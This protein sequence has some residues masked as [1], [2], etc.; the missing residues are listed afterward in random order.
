MGKILGGR[1]G[2]RRQ[3]RVVRALGV[4]VGLVVLMGGISGA[5]FPRVNPKG[6]GVAVSSPSAI[7]DLAVVSSEPSQ[8]ISGFGASGA[9]W[10]RDAKFFPAATR[11][12]IGRLLFSPQGIDL[13]TYRFYIGGGGV[14]VDQ[15]TPGESETGSYDRAQDGF[16]LGPDLYDWANEQGEQEFL[17]M[18]SA[19]HVPNLV[20]MSYSAPPQWTTDG[21]NCG[22]SIVTAD[23]G[24]YAAYLTTIVDHFHQEGINF[25]YV[26]AMNEPA[27]AFGSTSGCAQEGMVVPV[28]ERGDLVQA[29]GEDLAS[30]APYARVIAPDDVSTTRFVQ[31][32]PEWMS[33][34][35]VAKYVAA[36]TYHGYNFP[37][38]V[39][40]RAVAAVGKEF[41]KPT[42]MT[43]ICCE[44]TTTG[45]YG[46]QYNPTMSSGMWLATF[47]YQALRYSHDSSFQWWTALSAAMGCDPATD[48]G[49][50]T[51]VRTNAD[52]YNDGLIYYDPN[53][54]KDKD[55][56]LYPT[57]RLWVLGNY[58]RFVRPGAVTYDVT[59]SVPDVELLAFRARHG[60]W[61]II[62][63]DTA[64][65]GSS[66]QAVN[67]ELPCSAG[68]LRPAGAWRTSATDS[69]AP[70]KS[71]G[72]SGD[73]AR[74]DLSPQSITSY[75]LDSAAGPVP[76]S[77]PSVPPSGPPA[78]A[79]P[80]QQGSPA[81]Q[82]TVP[83]ACESA[84]ATLTL[85]PQQ[86][87]LGSTAPV[88]VVA[89][90]HNS[91][92]ATLSN[93][94][95]SL[96]GP[97]GVTIK[98]SETSLAPSAPSSI[99]PGGNEEETFSVTSSAGVEPGPVALTGQADF[100]AGSTPMESAVT[101]TTSLTVAY[102]NFQSAY[103]NTGI[104]SNTDVQPHAGLLG[105]DGH[106]TTYSAQGLAASGVTP[107]GQVNADGLTFTWPDVAA[108]VRDNVMTAGQVIQMSGS[109]STLGFLGAADNDALSGSG[110]VVY[111]D[112]SVQKFTIDIGNFWYPAGQDGNPDNT[113]VAS[114]FANY[115][116]GTSEGT[117]Y[118]H[119]V[120][121]FGSTV[122]I[123]P[124][125]TVS[126]VVLPDTN[127][128]TVAGYT[129]VIHLFD[130]TI[131]N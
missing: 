25:S 34:P 130:M 51:R 79:S 48:P 24:K 3:R 104:T 88:D 55:Y 92:T 20:A 101:A 15:A 1:F 114:S 119:T 28:S 125:E 77:G 33:Q 30:S 100:T 91:S 74:L 62:A 13:S 43:E 61:S 121:L 17:R 68:Q 27:D 70:V 54:A 12:Q 96:S 78:P 45:G 129:A 85:T 41:G 53:Y 47:I 95:F 14:G 16:Y 82:S 56:T 109:G 105:F 131:G 106:G 67:L 103:D 110:E 102:D 2:L 50:A 87:I 99:G 65:K 19:Y 120:Y 123:N 98:P 111:T 69:L 39:E 89:E 94:V 10:P 5:A 44:V 97:A 57:K 115:P 112:G 38:P 113:Q 72:V 31:T 90:L 126:Y 71:A 58:S 84:G 122:A 40:D 116:T 117:S 128:G 64:P 9:W 83:A 21:R 42:W 29:L 80:A 93:A 86:T 37:G 36:L 49:C 11:S 63:I 23:I 118:Q 4:G 18:A 7:P 6:P 46:A 8:T 76:P 73:L 59:T 52:T 35:N 75:V 107:G 66:S 22:G 81:V 108:G 124:S 127:G 32:V 26:S 60:D